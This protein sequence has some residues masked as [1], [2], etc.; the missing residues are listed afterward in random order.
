[1]D[2][3]KLL[4]M[5]VVQVKVPK[6]IIKASHQVELFDEDLNKEPYKSYWHKNLEPFPY[7]KKYV[8]CS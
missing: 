6:E 3:K 2:L 8:R 1:M 5:E 4:A 7:K